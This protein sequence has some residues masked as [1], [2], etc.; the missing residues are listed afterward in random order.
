MKTLH[1][2]LITIA[3]SASFALA[4][5]DDSTAATEFD[6]D[7]EFEDEDEDPSV[8]DTTTATPAPVAK[9]EEPKVVEAK[10]TVQDMIDEKNA[11]RAAEAEAEKK[12]DEEKIAKA[13][14]KSYGKAGLSVNFGLLLAI[15]LVVAKN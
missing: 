7:D 2:V 13:N 11:K 1:L 10:T 14:A 8:A 6:D 4:S 5:D 15:M 12:D 3:L 9:V